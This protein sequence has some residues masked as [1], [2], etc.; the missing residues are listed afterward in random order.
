MLRYIFTRTNQNAKSS[1]LTHSRVQNGM[2]NAPSDIRSNAVKSP[3]HVEVTSKHPKAYFFLLSV[4]LYLKTYRSA[5]HRRLPAVETTRPCQGPSLHIGET[6]GL[7]EQLRL[8]K[9]SLQKCKST[10]IDDLYHYM[11]NFQKYCFKVAYLNLKALGLCMWL[12]KKCLHF[13][14]HW[15]HIYCFCAVCIYSVVSWIFASSAYT[16][17]YTQCMRVL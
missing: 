10:C 17:S 16:T 9:T 1:R 4:N 12:D 7:K 2:Y 5:M 11:E 14:T 3:L 8:K 15:M 6:T 13:G